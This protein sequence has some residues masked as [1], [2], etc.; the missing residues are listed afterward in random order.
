LPVQPGKHE[1]TVLF[2]SGVL[3]G[4]PF[5]CNVLDPFSI[6]MVKHL[7]KSSSLYFPIQKIVLL[8]V[9]LK[10]L[11]HLIK[12]GILGPSQKSIDCKHSNSADVTLL[13]FQPEEL[14]II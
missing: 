5:I 9:N 13:K 2:N 6:T 12:F 11:E 1:I 7:N 8:E 10:N 3:D 4:S 14:G